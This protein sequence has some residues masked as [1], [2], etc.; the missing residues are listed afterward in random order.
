MSVNSKEVKD[1][2]KRRI[3]WLFVQNDS[4]VKAALANLRRGI[5]RA[6]G[7]MPE[8]WGIVLQ[9][10]PEEMMSRGGEPSKAEWASYTALTL[11]ALH[12]QGKDLQSERMYKEGASLG[13]SV[14]RLAGNEDE[15]QAVTR[16]FNAMATAS[17]MVEAA[18]H[19][20]GLVQLM[21]SKSIPLD[22]PALAADLFNYQYPERV[23]DIRLRWGEAY[24]K[25]YN[26]DE[27]KEEQS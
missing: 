6:P 22:Y 18:H 25:N 4:L 23:S 27:G 10:M 16:R 17:D 5:G 7:D 2:V 3:E 14:R 11:F 9:D 24:Y 12:Q 21:R 15:R 26:Q 13:D 8:L 19:M 20:R 1:F